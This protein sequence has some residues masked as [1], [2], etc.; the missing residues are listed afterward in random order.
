M[1]IFLLLKS[2][3]EVNLTLPVRKLVFDHACGWIVSPPAYCCHTEGKLSA[4]RDTV[5]KLLFLGQVDHTPLSSSPPVAGL[6]Q[7]GLHKETV[8][9]FG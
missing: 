7:E 8:L 1:L 3:R 6:K 2:Q 5:S 4:P 9:I